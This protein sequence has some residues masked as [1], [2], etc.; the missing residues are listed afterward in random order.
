MLGF[1]INLPKSHLFS[2]FSTKMSDLWAVPLKEVRKELFHPVD[3]DNKDSSDML[4]KLLTIVCR[5]WI[6]ELVDPNKATFQF[7]SESESE[8]C[9]RGCPTRVKKTLL[10]AMAVND[11]AESSSIGATSHVQAW[12]E[13]IYRAL[14]Q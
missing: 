8:V 14:P 7:L 6:D 1:T 2:S 10:G 5:A 12:E 11:L 9:W 3:Q 4:E 13:L